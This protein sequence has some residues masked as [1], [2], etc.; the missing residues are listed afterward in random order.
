LLD[1][2]DLVHLVNL[3]K[4]NDLRAIDNFF[5]DQVHYMDS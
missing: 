3:R 2:N 5:I 1:D 4:M